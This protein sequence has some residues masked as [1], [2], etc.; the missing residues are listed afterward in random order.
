M[1]SLSVGIMF[2]LFLPVLEFAIEFSI[3]LFPTAL[4]LQIACL[5]MID[6]SRVWKRAFENIQNVNFE[7]SRASG[8]SIA[9]ASYR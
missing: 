8:G 3:S 7:Y 9:L 6:M 4:F 2:D 1:L 5:T